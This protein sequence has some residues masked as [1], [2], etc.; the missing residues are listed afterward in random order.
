L[1]EDAEFPPIQELKLFIGNLA[2]K[3]RSGLQMAVSGWSFHTA[4]DFILSMEGMVSP[5]WLFFFLPFSANFE[6]LRGDVIAQKQY[7]GK[8]AMT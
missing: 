5:S 8:S 2:K 4:R 1:A 7:Q 6:S 3:G